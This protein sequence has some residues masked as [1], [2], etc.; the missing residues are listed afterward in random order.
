[1]A[2]A[3]VIAVAFANPGRAADTVTESDMVGTWC[4]ESGAQQEITCDKFTGD[5]SI[6]RILYH[7]DLS[8]KYVA[9]YQGR[10][11]LEGNVLHMFW[12]MGREN[13]E[14]IRTLSWAPDKSLLFHE[15]SGAISKRCRGDSGPVHCGV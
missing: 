8:Q 15:Q 10:W 4:V 3:A 12:P 5:H 13:A 7:L 14:Y 9:K 6:I 11:K 1:M 2:A